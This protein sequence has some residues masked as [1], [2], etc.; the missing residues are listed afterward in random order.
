MTPTEFKTIIAKLG[1][2]QEAAGEWLGVSRRQGQR[3][4]AGD[5]EI[6]KSVGM[7]LRVMMKHKITIDQ[8]DKAGA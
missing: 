4:A 2:S 7:L 6:P 3:W 1:F 5:R 8:V